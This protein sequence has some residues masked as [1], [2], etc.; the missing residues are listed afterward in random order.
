MSNESGW[1][2]EVG[3]AT[4]PSVGITWSEVGVAPT[5]TTPIQ[6]PAKFSQLLATY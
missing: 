4:T 5:G 3:E 1:W 2:G 6:N